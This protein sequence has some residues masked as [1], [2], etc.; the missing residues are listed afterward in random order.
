MKIIILTTW[1]EE[2]RWYLCRKLTASGITVD[3]YWPKS[4]IPQGNHLTKFLGSLTII[5]KMISFF[6]QESGKY[7]VVISWSTNTGAFYALMNRMFFW[8]K[9]PRHIV[10]DFHINLE[11]SDWGYRLKT[12]IVRLVIPGMDHCMCTSREEIDIYAEIFRI[13]RERLSFYPDSPPQPY[14]QIR[15]EGEK[16]DYIF[17]YGNSDRDF[18][19][20]LKAATH[21]DFDLIILS[22][23]YSPQIS[24]P[25]NVKLIKQKISEEKMIELIWYARVVV[26]PMQYYRV[27]AGQNGMLETMAL[28]RPL[29]VS[30][31][32]ATIEY[33]RHGETVLFF[34]PGDS[35]SLQTHIVS[36]LKDYERAENMGKAAREAVSHIPEEQ[37]T[38][39]LEVLKR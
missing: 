4:M 13:S 35:E 31:N 19:T 17:S 22:Q 12:A 30:A 5:I 3:T 38:K 6:L 16:K 1:K 33:G 28:G 26:L 39:L 7:D 8:K 24:L 21:I 27:A 15:H 11:R 2:N 9:R 25:A 37:V 32:L 10:R 29:V 20:L 23:N 34:N 14:F 18:D 36:L